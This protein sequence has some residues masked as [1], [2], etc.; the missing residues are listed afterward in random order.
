MGKSPFENKTPENIKKYI[1]LAKDISDYKQRLE[2]INYLSK[3]RCYES[4]KILYK[5]MNTDKIFSV[6]EQAFRALQNFG[7]NVKLRRKKKGKLIKSI[8]DKL[9][10]LH[11]SFNGDS[12]SLIDFKVRFK[13]KYPYIYDVYQY[14]KRD[15]F[16][17]FI[18]NSIKTFP[19]TKIYHHYVIQI[20]FENPSDQIVNEVFD[21]DYENTKELKD[22]LII[23]KQ[24][25]RINCVR[26]SKINL[27][28]II[29]FEDNSIHSQIIKSLIYF[30]ISA[31]QFNRIINIEII[32]KN[33]SDDE[34][35]LELPSRKIE[36]Q[37]ILNDN[38]VG[39][40][41]KSD[42]IKH[43]FKN[44]EKS[45]A[46]KYALTYL[47][48]SSIIIDPSSRF[49][50]LW[51]SF[52]SIY[53][54]I[55]KS[56]NEN[57]CHRI[58]RKYILD[59]SIRFEETINLVKDISIEEIR[60]KIRMDELIQNDYDSQKKV[61]SFIA[62]VYRYSDSTI[63]QLLLENIGYQKKYLESI[64]NIDKIESS[65]NKFD[66]IKHIYK[67]NKNSND[68]KIYYKIV[69]GYLKNNI[70]N[71]NIASKIEII[72]FICI[73]Y[74]YFLRNQL[75]HAEKHDLTF[76]FAKN[77]LV[78]ELSWINQILESLIIDLIKDNLNW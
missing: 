11:N 58:L 43:I 10:I 62:F 16:D 22:K 33:T 44:D 72:I 69:E 49:E 53:R 38:Y 21:L 32:R 26:D 34:V 61:V 70:K 25:I 19:K 74:S 27:N 7:E 39:F 17:V 18:E 9:L 31:N 20:H 5:L 36:L 65:F 37:Q 8:N 77:N 76:R 30:Y 15:K 4:K 3:Y 52:N 6:Q 46:L 35:K 66:N 1:E 60:G 13:E 28:N 71:L 24:K 56:S 41:I 42:F 14:E 29:F 48:K 55:G 63:S 78:D 51:K 45:L 68:K 64:N 47:L 50:K 40:N 59:N 75:F 2:A 12:Y 54:Y 67:T 23:D 73:K 57:E